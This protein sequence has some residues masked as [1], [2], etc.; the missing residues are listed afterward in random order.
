M[1]GLLFRPII[2]ISGKVVYNG[3]VALVQSDMKKLVAYSSIAHM[4]FVTLGF[5]LLNARLPWNKRGRVFLGDS[6]SLVLGLLL[7]WQFIDLGNGNDRAFVNIEGK[8]H[9]LG[10]WGS[11]ESKRKFAELVG[12]GWH[13]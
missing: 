1:T 12:G 13:G 10:T 2:G 3:F 6:G 11:V 4:G 7:A 8:R 9:Y 5:F